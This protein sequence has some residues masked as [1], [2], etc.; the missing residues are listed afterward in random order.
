MK[1]NRINIIS[2]DN[3]QLYLSQKSWG[4]LRNKTVLVTGA[5][6]MLA[7]CMVRF[8]V[9]LN[10][11][12]QLNIRVLLL[13]RSEQ[14]V[15]DLFGELTG[16]FE[17]F[18]QDV[19][20]PIEFDDEVDFVIHAAS[21]AS[22]YHIKHD[23][24][25]IIQT[26]VVGTMNLLELVKNKRVKN[27]LFM[28]TRE[29]YGN[30]ESQ[31]LIRERDFGS[32]DPL[33]SRSCY[34]ESKRMAETLLQSYAIQHDVPFTAVRIAHSYGPGMF[35][36]DGRVMS[37]LVGCVIDNQ[38][39]VLKSDGSA[40]RSFCYV[41]DAVSA[42]LLVLLKGE[43]NTAYNI[44]N[45]TEEVSI[46]QLAN[47]LSDLGGGISSVKHEISNDNAYCQYKRTKLCTEKIEALS[48]KP[49]VDLK[50]GLEKT[51]EFIR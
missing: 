43:V 15:Q 14:K 8:F 26:N 41:T 3:E 23:P 12:D 29:V 42:M 28:S 32:F 20:Q 6:G 37:D 5:T 2:D 48:W 45:E 19:C 10:R 50:S 21:N 18:Y 4:S 7:A 34:P 44:A 33:D 17:C 27:F 40:L 31:E 11:K 30:L 46:L 36:N 22:P 1:N 47:L 9:Y 35:L 39:I 51:I 25:G 13:A 24:V 38:P 49:R 16:E